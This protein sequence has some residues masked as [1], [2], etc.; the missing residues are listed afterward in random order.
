MM[1]SGE[2][3]LSLQEQHIKMKY[4]IIGVPL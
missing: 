1:K 4:N 2:A 3:Q